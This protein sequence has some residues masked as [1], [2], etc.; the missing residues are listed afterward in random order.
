MCQ[1]L[2]CKCQQIGLYSGPSG[3]QI[4]AQPSATVLL[5]SK[6]KQSISQAQDYAPVTRAP[7]Q[8]SIPRKCAIVCL[9][10]NMK[11]WIFHIRENTITVAKLQQSAC[12][13][14]PGPI[15]ILTQDILPALCF[16]IT[17][18]TGNMCRFGWNL[19]SRKIQY[20]SKGCLT[21]SLTIW[22]TFGPLYIHFKTTY[23]I[24]H[25]SLYRLR[26]YFRVQ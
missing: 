16:V 26:R 6:V 13:G 5:P 23:V 14:W 2:S 25:A 20:Y 7:F 22:S 11:Y 18:I 3:Y 12:A 15:L 21:T 10:W 8:F 4:P 1:N 24:V 9:L 17:F 19:T